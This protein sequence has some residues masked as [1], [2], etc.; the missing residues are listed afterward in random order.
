MTR[1]VRDFKPHEQVYTLLEALD[2]HLLSEI[3]YVD[4][5]WIKFVWLSVQILQIVDVQL[6]VDLQGRLIRIARSWVENLN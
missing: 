6:S 3:R 2:H 4:K 5:H 1:C